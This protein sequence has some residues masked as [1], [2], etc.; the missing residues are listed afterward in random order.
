M[1][2]LLFG[3]HKKAEPAGVVTVSGETGITDIAI[4]RVGRAVV[5]VVDDGTMDKIVNTTTTQID[6]STDWLV[7]PGPAPSDYQARYTN[8]TG[9]ALHAS[10]TAAEDV[11]HALSAS[12][13]FFEQRALV[14]N[15]DFTS[16]FTVEIRKGTG[17]VL[18]SDSYTIRASRTDI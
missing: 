6:A 17:P 3:H 5:V 1:G 16:T 8:L 12:S 9:A 13:F 11:W 18:D 10:T 14:D 15:D 2:L 4:N 7:P